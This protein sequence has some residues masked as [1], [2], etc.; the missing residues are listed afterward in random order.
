MSP[1][2]LVDLP[3]L[4]APLR[5]RLDA[6][7]AG[8]LD[9][10]DF[11]QGRDVAAFEAEVAA[12]MGVAHALGVSSGTDAL[13]VALMALDVGPG[14][15][16]VTTT[17]SFFATVGSIA[18]LGARPV[19]VDIDP[20]SFNLD[21]ERIEEVLSE[22]TRAIMPVH[23]FGRAADMGRI[24]AIAARHRLPVVEDAAQAIGAEHSGRRVGSIGE[25][26]CLSFFPAKNLG[27]FGDGGLV[28]T[29]DAELAERVRRLRTHGGQKQYDHQEVGGNFRLDTLQAAVLR[30]KLPELDTWTRLRQDAAW[31]YHE[32]FAAHGLA[33][34]V[35]VPSPGPGRHVWNQYVVRVLGGRRDQVLEALRAAGIGCAVYYAKPLHEQPCFAALGYAPEAFPEAT[36]A[37]SEALALPIAPGVSADDQAVVVTTIARA[38]GG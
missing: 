29:D 35:T 24:G 28:T 18:R 20:E 31:R 9:R 14:D 16:V 32:L 1:I 30:V 19:L 12:Y 36:R 13:L 23:L 15:E 3:A 26:G 7:I 38:L 11:I 2:P 27:C 10:N 6:A 21:P 37:A 25:L 17:Y 33:D 22:R 5:D 34:R 8:V 4:H